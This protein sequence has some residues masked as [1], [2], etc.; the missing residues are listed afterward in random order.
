MPGA[1]HVTLGWGRDYSDVPPLK[2]VALGGAQQI[3]AV[4]V[5]VTPERAAR[6]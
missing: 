3:I 1:G 5:R 6:L 4:E 2:G